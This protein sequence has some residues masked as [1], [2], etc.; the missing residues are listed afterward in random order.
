MCAMG[1]GSFGGEKT[2]QRH[3]NNHTLQKSLSGNR[4]LSRT[5]PYRVKVGSNRD[6]VWIR[7]WGSGE[8]REVFLRLGCMTSRQS[9]ACSRHSCSSAGDEAALTLG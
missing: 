5:F 9:G 8:M 6:D 4:G 7:L 1:R 2:N 3:Q